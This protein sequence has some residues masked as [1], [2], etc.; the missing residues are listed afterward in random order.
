[1]ALQPNIPTH[2]WYKRV[3]HVRIPRLAESKATL[4]STYTRTPAPA[5]IIVVPVPPIINVP[6]P[7]NR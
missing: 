7:P 6:T 5:P 4:D 3:N 2:P 1:M